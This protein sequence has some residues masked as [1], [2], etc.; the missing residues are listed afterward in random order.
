[1]KRFVCI[2][3]H[4][5]QPPRE[6]PWLEEI[7]PQESAFPYHDWNERISAEC[8]AR[9]GASRILDQEGRVVEIV[10]TYSKISFNMGATL[11]SWMEK[12][13]PQT[14]QSVLD[15]D[16]ISCERF[17]GHGSAMAQVYNHMIMPLSN[18]RDK[19]TQVVWG[20]RDFESRFKRAPE[21]MWL[22]EA[23]VDLESLDIMAEHGIKFTV[24]APHQARRVRKISVKAAAPWV[25]GDEEPIDL[26]RPYLCRLPSGRTIA[27]FFYDGPIARAVAFEGLLH[28][29]EALANRVLGA[30]DADPSRNQLVHIATD[31]ESYGHH[32]KFGDM[33]L[34]YALQHI[35]Q[36][37]LAQITVYGQYLA[38]NPPQYEAEIVDKSSWSCVHGVER[39]RENCGCNSGGKPGWHQEWR[40]PLREAL[41][42]LRDCATVV[43]EQEMKQYT[44]DP[45]KLR[46]LY[47]DVI[48]DRSYGNAERFIAEH[49]RAG[50]D[51][52]QKNSILRLL[53]IQRNA[54]L[55]Y[56]SCGWFFDDISGIE[57]VQ[58]I[59][60]AA[61][62]IQLVEYVNDMDF[63][64]GF[65]EILGKAKSNVPEANNG[66]RIYKLYVEP[67]IVDILRVGAHYAMS[68]LYKDY[69]DEEDLYCY[70]VRR[71]LYERKSV[72]KFALV[73]GHCAIVSTVTWT[74]FDV[75]FVVLHL[76]DH[77]FITGVDH[78]KDEVV[79]NRM[80]A[81]L[82]RIFL[83]GDVPK[84]LQVINKYFGGKNYSLWHLFKYEQQA[85]LEKIFESTMRE[86]ETSFRGIYED[87]Y[88]L[89]RMINDNHM[90]LPKTLSGVVEFI[91]NRDMMRI[92]EMPE[93]PLDRLQKMSE[94]VSRWPFKRG[95]EQLDF[96]GANKVN[97]MMGQFE[98]DPNDVVLL[99]KI[100]EVVRIL[101]GLK[102]DLDFWKAQNSYYRICRTV[103]HEKR[104]GDVAPETV[105]WLKSFDALG[106]MFKMRACS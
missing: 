1:M 44:P 31:G 25:P 54:L 39:W 23:A 85:I 9:N 13:D 72:G 75:Q 28:N 82:L 40:A 104:R 26:R 102:F 101:T 7:E 106:V 52:H 100:T 67:S 5:Y 11:L 6:N 93:V 84:T 51:V 18:T 55:M 89:L 24:L 20:I 48:L 32:H 50:L 88:S 46:D 57:T 29:G 61:R 45:W 37:G 38:D 21:G 30:L 76:G 87:H 91:L 58:I 3:G 90:P 59:K 47:I 105:R 66:A 17:G 8:Y 86:V 68:S 99:E 78:F 77:N 10:N 65:I 42:W 43:Y 12:N 49:V 79:F 62:V 70:K 71:K 22:A 15:A 41:D 73:I 34:A 97:E 4:F 60:Y 95:K 81:E 94:E 56:T 80:R 64:L 83:D 92:L 36:K 69:S 33:A 27:L 53:E 98:K 74:S 35:E 103:C 2:H 96:S 63:E 14:Y 19:R 16:R